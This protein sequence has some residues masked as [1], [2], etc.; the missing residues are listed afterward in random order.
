MA[1]TV[2][3]PDTYIQTEPVS[4]FLAGSIEMG[5]A[6]D[7]QTDVVNRLSSHYC[8]FLNPRRRDWDSSWKQSID[9]PEF[10]KQVEWELKGLDDA[11]II[12]MY[13]ASGTMS[14]I[15]ILEFGRH[16]DSKKM[17]VYCPDDFWRKGNIDVT[18]ARH[19]VPVYNNYEDFLNALSYEIYRRN[20]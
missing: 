1:R 20:G 16:L 18:A 5:K 12:A 6:T 9:N 8:L 2:Y 10:R 19:S 17:I 11:D 14:P 13:F 7:W 15:S 3:A 4:V